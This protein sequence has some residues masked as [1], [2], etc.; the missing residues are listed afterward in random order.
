MP[1][2]NVRPQSLD[3]PIGPPAGRDV[4]NADLAAYRHAEDTERERVGDLFEIAVL[5]RASGGGVA[6]DA[7]LMAR[8]RLRDDEVAHVAEDP[9]HRRT[10][11]V[12]D[13]KAVHAGSALE[14]TLAHVD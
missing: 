6:D 3:K 9:S 8:R 13:A 4:G 2:Q 1:M 12:N 14:Q 7:D 10:E 11:A 5:K